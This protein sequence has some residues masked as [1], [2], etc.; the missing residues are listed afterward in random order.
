MKV[1]MVARVGERRGEAICDGRDGFATV[2][3]A[4][5]VVAEAVVIVR[6]GD[7]LVARGCW[8]GATGHGI[9]DGLCSRDGG[10]ADAR[11]EE[12]GRGHA[13]YGG[14]LVL[15]DALRVMLMKRA[16][17]GR[18]MMASG[19]WLVGGGGEG[20]VVMACACGSG[21]GDV[22]AGGTLLCLI[23]EGLSP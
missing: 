6:V 12:G 3:L 1:G 4:G 15:T 2:T 17:A 22:R 16:G 20:K 5:L 7:V 19:R 14:A 13:V 11:V 21:R 9:H 8:G 18:G 10:T 23:H